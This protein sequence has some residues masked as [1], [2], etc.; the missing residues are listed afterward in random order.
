[1]KCYNASTMQTVRRADART[2]RVQSAR[3]AE[4]RP[5]AGACMAGVLA[6]RQ[7]AIRASHRGNAMTL[8]RYRDPK[9]RQRIRD[10]RRAENCERKTHFD[11]REAA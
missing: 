8:R 10:L 3:L 2:C 9:L 11:T 6:A 4:L 7:P 5:A 1:M